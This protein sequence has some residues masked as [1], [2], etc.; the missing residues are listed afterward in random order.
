MNGFPD[1][2]HGARI[3]IGEH[4]FLVGDDLE[5][6]FLVGDD[7]ENHAG[8]GLLLALGAAHDD[9]ARAARADIHRHARR[10]PR[11]RRKPLLEKLGF[12]PRPEHGLRRG[13]DD[14]GDDGV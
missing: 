1:G 6:H 11:A 2:I 12:G 3:G 7:L 9:E 13:V 14:A 4:D 10:R 8:A 5:N